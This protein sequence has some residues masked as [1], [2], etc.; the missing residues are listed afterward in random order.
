[1]V[2]KESGE[3]KYSK[4]LAFTCGRRVRLLMEIST[5]FSEVIP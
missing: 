1:M 3:T 5:E 4:T 2:S